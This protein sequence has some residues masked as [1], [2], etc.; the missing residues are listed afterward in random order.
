MNK[1]LLVLRIGFLGLCVGASLLLCYTI[2]EWD[3]YR[4]TAVLVG[5]LIGA[6]IVLVD[7]LLKGFSLR[8][9][10]ALTFGLGIGVVLAWMIGNVVCHRDHKDNIYPNK[11]RPELKIDGA[12]AL[13]MAIARMLAQTPVYAPSEVTFV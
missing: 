5:V 8:G 6:L 2:R 13:I 9:L 12:I 4:T 10:S 1:T 3:H 7:I 11:Q